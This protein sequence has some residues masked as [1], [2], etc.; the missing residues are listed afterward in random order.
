M[1]AVAEVGS[2]LLTRCLDFCQALSNQGQAFNFSVAVGPDFTFSLDT[3]RKERSKVAKKKA[4][5][6]TVKRNARRKEE[7]LKQKNNPSS[8]NTTEE[9]EIVS[10]APKCDQCNYKA[11]SEKGLRQHQRMKHKPSMVAS[12]ENSEN[13]TSPECE[14]LREEELK[15]SLNISQ[16]SGTRDDEISSVDADLSLLDATLVLPHYCGPNLERVETISEKSVFACGDCFHLWRTREEVQNCS[17]STLHDCSPY[18]LYVDV[19]NKDCTVT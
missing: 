4:S 6:S 14:I 13:Q 10:D 11:A 12:S 15:V 18:C 8:V 19:L 3:R 9:L 2:S 17:C 16:P 7:Y 1:A 5:P